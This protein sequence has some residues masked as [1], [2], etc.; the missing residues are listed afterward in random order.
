MILCFA[1]CSAISRL[2]CI[3]DSFRGFMLRQPRAAS[4]F[5]RGK[6][7]NSAIVESSFSSSD[8]NPETIIDAGVSFSISRAGILMKFGNARNTRRGR[9]QVRQIDRDPENDHLDQTGS[10]T[11]HPSMLKAFVWFNGGSAG[12]RR[13]KRESDRCARVS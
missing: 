12:L 10:N 2:S 6:R 13:E 4:D 3:V 1:H 7:G 9:R 11:R 8:V 5:P